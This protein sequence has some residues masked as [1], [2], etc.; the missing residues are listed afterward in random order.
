MSRKKQ[1]KIEAL[2][3]IKDII[4]AFLFKLYPTDVTI[5]QNPKLTKSDNKKRFYKFI[6]K[7]YSDNIDVIKFQT[8]KS[9]EYYISVIKKIICKL[10]YLDDAMQKR[11][12]GIDPSVFKK[13]IIKKFVKN[14]Q[15]KSFKEI[16]TFCIS[17]AKG[18]DKKLL[19]GDR[20]VFC[21]NHL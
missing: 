18:K 4:T 11:I 1:P 20:F 7:N 3:S 10:S 14:L 15:K 13:D 8:P 2:L 17:M 16:R 12:R 21:V 6:D 19:N 5:I 9:N